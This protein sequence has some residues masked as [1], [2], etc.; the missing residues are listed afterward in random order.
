MHLWALINYNARPLCA[1]CGV[2]LSTNTLL[3]PLSST[4]LF[5][6]LLG[7]C[8]WCVLL[9]VPLWWNILSDLM[10]IPL[11]HRMLKAQS[12]TQFENLLVTFKLTIQQKSASDKKKNNWLFYWSQANHS[13]VGHSLIGLKSILALS[14]I[15]RV[16]TARSGLFVWDLN[17]GW[18]TGDACR[19]VE[20]SQGKERSSVT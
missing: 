19:A 7:R 2:S 6:M 20:G 16:E 9:K 11:C 12:H 4:Q 17:P 13:E 15:L 18:E 8:M 10:H 3:I 1:G 5:E 14:S